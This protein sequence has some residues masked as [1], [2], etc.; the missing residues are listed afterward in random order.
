MGSYRRFRRAL[1]PD[2]R[3][4]AW[5]GARRFGWRNL[6]CKLPERERRQRRP[7]PHA[8]LAQS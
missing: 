8:S 6:L 5:S 2:S 3:L 7:Q 4:H 1:E